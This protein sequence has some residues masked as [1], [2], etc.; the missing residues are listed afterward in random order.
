M[1]LTDSPEVVELKSEFR[2]LSHKENGLRLIYEFNDPRREQSRQRKE[3]SAV[4]I[5]KLTEARAA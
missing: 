2:K 3:Q 1:T 4:E 5:A